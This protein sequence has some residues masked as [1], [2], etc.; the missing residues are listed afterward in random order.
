MEKFNQFFRKIFSFSHTE[1]QGFIRLLIVCIVA[2]IVLFVP[3]FLSQEPELTN[4]EDSRK[5][6]SLVSL[7]ENAGFSHEEIALFPFDPNYLP[8]DSLILLGFARKV[9]ER[10][11]NY[12]KKGGKFY[13]KKELKKIYGL[14]D[15]LYEQLKA[16]ID[17]PD[18]S[19]VKIILYPWISILLDKMSL[20]RFD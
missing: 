20:S 7:F 8:I 12:R 14:S 11:D 13:T 3:K 16:F 2:L 17:L 15:P 5:L 1:S 19:T 18:S 4:A 6:D 9:A 10:V